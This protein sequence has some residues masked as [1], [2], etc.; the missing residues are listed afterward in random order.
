MKLIE[1]TDY[2]NSINIKEDILNPAHNKQHYKEENL[3]ECKEKCSSLSPKPNIH[4]KSA[5]L[6]P[7]KHE[8]FGLE[9]SLEIDDLLIKNISD[10]YAVKNKTNS[11]A[12]SEVNEE[13]KV[14]NSMSQNNSKKFTT[15]QNIRKVNF[16]L[17]K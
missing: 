13:V 11:D 16:I 15:Q 2:K 8:T 12:K 3:T 6:E 1:T 14:T 10:F 4:F 9:K 5:Q 7:S 17:F